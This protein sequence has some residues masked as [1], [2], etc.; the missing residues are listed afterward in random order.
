ML[1]LSIQSLNAL[2]GWVNLSLPFSPSSLD[3]MAWFKVFVK[4]LMVLGQ[5]IITA[6]SVA[7][8]E[9][10]LFRSWLP[11]EIAADL[12]FHQGIIISGLAFSLFQRYVY[13]SPLDT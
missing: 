3:A 12:G 2:L 8:V 7:L 4:M 13:S 6:T 10:L 11:E 1:V 5:G 9:E